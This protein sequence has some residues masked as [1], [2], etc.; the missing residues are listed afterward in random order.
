MILPLVLIA[1]CALQALY[2][3]GGRES[4]KLVVA[5]LALAISVSGYQAI[6]LNFV[7]YDND[8]KTIDLNF[9]EPLHYQYYTYVYAHTRRETLNLVNEINRIARVSGEGSRMGVTIVS[10]DYWPLPWY[11]RDYSRV[12]YYGRMTASTEP[13]VIASEA[14]RA[15]VLATFGERYQLVNSEL[16]P[17]GSYS[18]RPGV[19]LLIFVRRYIASRQ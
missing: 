5:I 14:Q 12:G 3:F 16:N 18:L 15:E 13:V 1:G 11:L 6:D 7:N 17:E 4:L 9:Q 2:E 10:P 8:K 19:E